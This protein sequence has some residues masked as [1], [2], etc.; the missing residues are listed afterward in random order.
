MV[1]HQ[2]L[3]APNSIHLSICERYIPPT[4]ANEFENLFRVRVPSLLVDRLVELAP[5]NGCMIFLYPTKT[6]AQ[7]FAQQYLAPVLDPVLRS[8]IVVNGFG[9]DLSESLGRMTSVERM[10]EF[11][12]MKS[13]AQALCLELNSGAAHV[14]A[15]LGRAQKS[16]FSLVYAAKH[17]VELERKVWADWW[18]RQEKQRIRSV[19]GQYFR[20]ARGYHEGDPAADKLPVTVVQ[21]VLEAVEKRPAEAPGS[22]IEV[23]VFVL[24]RSI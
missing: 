1:R 13:R 22:K 12:E 4:S 8:M 9:A 17:E 24:K 2:L 20:K 16:T 14:Q 21:E 5:G 18:V 15:R 11:E 3:A 23:G 7:T 10:M 19:V 6:G